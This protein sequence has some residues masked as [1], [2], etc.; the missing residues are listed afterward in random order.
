MFLRNE[1]KL[2]AEEDPAHGLVRQMVVEF[3]TT[4]SAL[5]S[6]GGLEGLPRRVWGPSEVGGDAHDSAILMRMQSRAA[7]VASTWR[8]NGA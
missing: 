4:I 2:F 7:T 6:F 1:A 5:A 3:E 8:C